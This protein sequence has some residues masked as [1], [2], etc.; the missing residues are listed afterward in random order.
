MAA[1]LNNGW[2]LA[3][4]IVRAPF[5]TF[6][7]AVE[8]LI[9]EL[10]LAEQLPVE[11]GGPALRAVLDRESMGSTALVEIGVSIPHAR[12]EGVAGIIAAVAVSS[13]AVYYAIADVPVNIM[14]LVLSSPALSG[15]H[16]N[17]L[18]LLSLLL[19]SDATRYTLQ[20]APTPEL[21]LES[22]RSHER[23]R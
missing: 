17:F 3:P 7:D 9:E 12:L 18:S 20:R 10:V 15:E 21:L 14:V 19:Q 5:S 22:L 4:V 2:E 8:G 23:F 11:L 6:E 1:R 16:L 13:S